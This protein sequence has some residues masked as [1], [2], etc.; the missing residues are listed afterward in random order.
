M[1]GL[2]WLCNALACPCTASTAARGSICVSNVVKLALTECDRGD[3]VA[4]GL[5]PPMAAPSRSHPVTA[6]ALTLTN[7][8]LLA[9][10][11]LSDAAPS[12]PRSAPYL[13]NQANSLDTVSSAPPLALALQLYSDEDADQTLGPD[14]DLRNTCA[15]S[16]ST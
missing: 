1:F 8:H 10:T 11:S 3:G 7:G 6:S 9:E 12:S 16:W 15:S 2:D 5:S 4:S 13:S 14:L